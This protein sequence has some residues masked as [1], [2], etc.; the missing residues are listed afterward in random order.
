MERPSAPVVQGG[1]PPTDERML[2]E[3]RFPEPDDV[4]VPDWEMF[5]AARARFE[6]AWRRAPSGSGG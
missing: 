3:P 1:L 2:S 4:L 6:R 5:Q